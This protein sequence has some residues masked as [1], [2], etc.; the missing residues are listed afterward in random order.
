MKTLFLYKYDNF[1]TLKFEGALACEDPDFAIDW[2]IYIDDNILS[3][4]HMNH[5]ILKDVEF[6]FDYRVN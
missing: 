4:K 5:E 3:K 1:C 2:Q 6:V